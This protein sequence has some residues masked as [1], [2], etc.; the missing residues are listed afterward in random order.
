MLS[1]ISPFSLSLSFSL[2][3]WLLQMR[4][5]WQ[6]AEASNMLSSISPFSLSLSLFLSL[7]LAAAD[8]KSCIR[9]SLTSSL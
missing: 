3:F 4:H 1:S 2:L 5:T 9:K 7:V 8:G 6:V